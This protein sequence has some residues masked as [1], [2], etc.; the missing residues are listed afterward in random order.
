MYPHDPHVCFP[1]YQ[2]L[3][4]G[5][6]FGHF[7]FFISCIRIDIPSFLSIWLVFR[8]WPLIVYVQ[9][10]VCY[11]FTLSSIVL[12]LLLGVSFGL[13]CAF[14]L[15]PGC[16][17][18][19]HW[20]SHVSGQSTMSTT[21]VSCYHHCNNCSSGGELECQLTIMISLPQ[22]VCVG[23]SLTFTQCDDSVSIEGQLEVMLDKRSLVY[24]NSP[25]TLCGHQNT[26]FHQITGSDKLEYCICSLRS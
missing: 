21:D 13:L 26:V 11:V 18:S 19:P 3:V 23:Q 6:T 22:L 17:A 2:S 8:F 14:L 12:F 7:L 16:H 15:W 24:S 9:I 25:S 10:L 5:P 1:R 20:P 4:E